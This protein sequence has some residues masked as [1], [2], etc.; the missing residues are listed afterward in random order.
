LYDGLVLRESEYDR[1]TGCGNT[2][3]PGLCRGRR[4]TGVPTARQAQE[5]IRRKKGDAFVAVNK[6]VVHDERLKQSR[7]HF[8]KILVVASTG[9]M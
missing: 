7:R 9:T 4:V 1:R 6:R 2:A 3:R 8:G 5:N